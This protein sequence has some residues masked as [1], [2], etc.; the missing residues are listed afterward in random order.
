MGKAAPSILVAHESH[1]ENIFSNFYRIWSANSSCDET[2]EIAHLFFRPEAYH[3]TGIAAIST[4]ETELPC[5][6]L[7]SVFKNKDRGF[8]YFESKMSS[9]RSQGVVNVGLQ[10]YQLVRLLYLWK[11]S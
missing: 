11:W 6:I 2:L 4:T 3:F 5:H 7:I 9:F 1:R 10:N 8:V